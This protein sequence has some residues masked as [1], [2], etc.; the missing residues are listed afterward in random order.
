MFS[1]G[2]GLHDLTEIRTIDLHEPRGWQAINIGDYGRNG[3]IQ[4]FL[5]QISILTNHQNGKDTHLRGVMIGT[6]AA[7][8]VSS[9]ESADMESSWLSEE[10]KRKFSIR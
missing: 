1:A 10:E 4:A 2:T 8:Q 6:P 9:L 7:A 5:L 3:V